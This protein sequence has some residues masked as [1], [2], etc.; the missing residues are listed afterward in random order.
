[1]IDVADKQK[2]VLSE[3]YDI[4]IKRINQ[5]QKKGQGFTITDLLKVD[6]RNNYYYIHMTKGILLSL[7]GLEYV[8]IISLYNGYKNFVYLCNKEIKKDL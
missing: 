7:M 1:M 6:D 3:H 2:Q 4:I 5:F 8:K